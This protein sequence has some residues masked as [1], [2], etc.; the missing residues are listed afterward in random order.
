MGPNKSR[1]FPQA[2]ATALE[3]FGLTIFL[4]IALYVTVFS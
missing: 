3:A 2:F 1:F 4:A